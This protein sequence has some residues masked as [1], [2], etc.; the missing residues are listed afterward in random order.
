MS[1][2]E[3]ASP[4]SLW[5]RIAQAAWQPT[6]DPRIHALL[7]F[8]VTNAL[9]YL[10]KV[11]RESGSHVTLTH[12]VAK[13][14]ALAIREYPLLNGVI[15]CGRFHRRKTIDVFVLAAREKQADEVT[16]G[17]GLSGV[18]ISEADKQSLPQ[19]ADFLAR[20]VDLVR[21]K[22]DPVWDPIQASLEYVP[23]VLLRP[24]LKTLN[25]LSVD[26]DLDLSGLGFPYD[27][28]GSAIVS[29][30]GMLGL[31]Q[32]LA[33]FFPLARCPLLISVGEVRPKALVVKGRVAARPTLTLGITA[34]HRFVDGLGAARVV[35]RLREVLENPQAALSEER[36]R[37]VPVRR[38]R[39]A[40]A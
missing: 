30:V 3:P 4:V 33:P 37:K 10:V 23:G 32:G 38:A 12:L 6:D 31:S 20:R 2:F 39:R 27:P 5:R 14:I 13:A 35:P 22:Q 26:L 11:R 24:L 25:F 19:M 17:G 29:N 15:R 34:D 8:D 16:R 1:N 21:K 40:S 28:F 9:D 18:K 36:P 7:D